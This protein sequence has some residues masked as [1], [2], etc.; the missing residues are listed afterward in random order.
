M[1]INIRRNK[2]LQTI[3]K[4]ARN[5]DEPN[6]ELMLLLGHLIA[7]DSI[8]KEFAKPNQ[9]KLYSQHIND[10]GELS[11]NALLQRAA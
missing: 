6:G 11:T 3:E 2:I 10:D 5:N 7:F 9:T 1:W 8:S 4:I